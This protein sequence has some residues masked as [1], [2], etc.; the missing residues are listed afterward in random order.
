MTVRA[1]LPMAHA[2]IRMTRG[3]LVVAPLALAALDAGCGG[4]G[5][6]GTGTPGP[7]EIAARLTAEGWA[8]FEAGSFVEASAKFREA[9]AA[10]ATYAEARNG[11]GWSLARLDSLDRSQAEFAAAVAGG[12]SGAEPR[13]GLAFVDAELPAA[14]MRSASLE[15]AIAYAKAALAIAPRFVFSHDASVDWRDLRLLLAQAYFE[16]D[17]LARA[18][19]EVESLGG[20]VP[21]PGAPGEADSLLLEIERLGEGSPPPLVARRGG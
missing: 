7:S 13:A 15:D 17:S 5:S 16:Q 6:G 3:L 19:A 20:R 18:A 4:G 8:L 21:A 1:R 14:L 12:H 9:L 2:L 10:L 11:L